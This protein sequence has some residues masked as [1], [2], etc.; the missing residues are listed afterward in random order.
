M[1]HLMNQQFQDFHKSLDAFEERP[2]PM[3]DLTTFRRE[4]TSL[5]AEIDAFLAPSTTERKYS[6]TTSEDLV[7]LNALFYDSIPPQASSHAVGKRH[8]L[9]RT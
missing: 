5:R 8:I 2:S 1:E 6:L 9:V 7:V 3:I 4:F